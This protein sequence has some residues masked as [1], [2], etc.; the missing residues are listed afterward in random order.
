LASVDGVLDKLAVKMK[1]TSQEAER[2]T[3]T[4][5]N[6]GAQDGNKD[7]EK[8]KQAIQVSV[9]LKSGRFSI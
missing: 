5:F 1:E 3:D 7:L 6:K 9:L 8:A 2:L 4:Q